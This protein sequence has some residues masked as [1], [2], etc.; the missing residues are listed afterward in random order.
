LFVFDVFLER[1]VS[2]EKFGGGKYFLESEELEV[3]LKFLEF[4]IQVC[5]LFGG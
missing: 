1:L 4:G 5:F 3:A 2:G